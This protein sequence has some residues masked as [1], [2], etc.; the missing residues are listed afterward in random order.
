MILYKWNRGDRV[1]CFH[2][3]FSAIV[4]HL[5]DDC[6][7]A[8]F[9]HTL[10]FTPDLYVTIEIKH[11]SNCNTKSNLTKDLEPTCESILIPFL[12]S[13]TLL[14]RDSFCPQLEIVIYKT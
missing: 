1:L 7:I 10:V 6:G 3:V 9:W 4:H 14:L 13:Y 8:F 2:E 11:R 5:R 12:V